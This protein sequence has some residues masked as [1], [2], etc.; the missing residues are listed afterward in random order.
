MEI[1]EKASGGKVEIDE[2]T[3][4]SGGPQQPA[5]VQ[6]GGRVKTCGEV[7]SGGASFGLADRIVR[8]RSSLAASSAAA[9]RASALSFSSA[10]SLFGSAPAAV[11]R[12]IISAVGGISSGGT[13][14]GLRGVDAFCSS[15]LV[16]VDRPGVV[17]RLA[18]RA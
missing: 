6:G 16:V 1:E 13:A 12:F 10:P 5:S 9:A 8:S 7:A 14:C 3:R 2:K 4:R 11:R 15:S 17:V 18:V